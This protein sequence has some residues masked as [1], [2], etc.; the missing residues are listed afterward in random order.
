MK[1]K[2]IIVIIGAIG[3]FILFLSAYVVNETQQVVITQFGKVIGEPITT[4]GLRFMVPVLQKATYF[5][6]NLLSW[7]GDP[8][9][10][11]TLEK[12]YIWVDSFARWKIVDPVK[13]FQTVNDLTRAKSRLDDII[14]PAV[15]NAI[16]SFRLIETVRKS[17]RV[18]DTMEIGIISDEVKE[19]RSTYAIETGREK[20]TQ[21]I[22]A[23]AQPKLAQFGIELV[24]VKIKRINYVDQVRKSVYGRMI[25]ERNQIAEKFR[26]EG[27]GE[28]KKILGEKERELKQI[29]S[30]AYRTA[31]E[32]K[33]KA[34]AEATRI[35]AAAFGVDPDFYSFIKTLETYKTTLD[36]NSTLVISTHS[37]F[38]KYLKGY[39][40]T[41]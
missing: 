2:G 10:V 16:T 11:P 1:P 9:Q 39:T 40:Q 18:L 25:A 38:L 35:F 5:P 6:K 12:T 32:I 29:T 8:G 31:Q 7:E 22:L 21:S 13:F 4:P 19:Q 17:N 41:P 30:E 14:D 3:A 20:I 23:Q 33:G 26:S 27:Q 34:D 36:A 15:R 24:D 37:D 28:A